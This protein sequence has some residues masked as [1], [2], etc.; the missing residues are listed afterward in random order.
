MSPDLKNYLRRLLLGY[1]F[2]ERLQED[3]RVLGRL[4]NQHYLELY[5][6]LLA[7]GSGP[8][9]NA[10]EFSRFSQNGEDGII[11]YLASRTGVN[12]HYIVEIGTEDGRECNSANL[13]LNF[14]WQG[15]L[16]EASK[17]WT[18]RGK[19]Y[20]SEQGA[21][22]RTT[23]INQKVTPSNVN[24]ILNQGKVPTDLEILSIDIDSYDYWVWEAV[25][26]YNPKIV[27]IEY[28]ASFGPIRSVSIPKDALENNRKFPPYY[29]GAS[30]AALKKL[31]ERKGYDLLGCD[32]HGVNSFFVRRDLTQNSGLKIQE[33]EEAYWKHFRR[34]RRKTVEQQYQEIAHL[35]LVEIN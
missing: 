33:T 13:I 7:P 11:L 17:K 34:S 23:I 3:H 24:D 10:Y 8:E 15:L 19:L 21:E 32:S 5:P 31:G 22:N 20:F 28:N 4:G 1:R 26:G 6:G 27:I 2:Q 30:L 25:D 29:H 18:D 12:R 16:I 9:I 14:G 35:P